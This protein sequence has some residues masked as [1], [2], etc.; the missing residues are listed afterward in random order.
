MNTMTQTE[1]KVMGECLT[2][3]DAIV[4]L[5]AKA[6]AYDCLLCKMDAR[7]AALRSGGSCADY[8]EAILARDEN[9]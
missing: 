8:E 6:G 9:I 7:N 1:T 5:S 4:L 2:C 3:G